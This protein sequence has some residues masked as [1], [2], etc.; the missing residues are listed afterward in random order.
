MIVLTF[1]LRIQ[2]LLDIKVLRA[3][4]TATDKTILTQGFVNPMI[5]NYQHRDKIVALAERKDAVNTN[6]SDKMP[7]PVR[8]FQTLLPFIKCRDYAETAWDGDN[9]TTFSQLGRNNTTEGM[10]ATSSKDWRAQN[11][12]HSRL[13]QMFSPEILF[14]P[15][16]I[17]S[18]YELYTVGLMKESFSANWSTETNP[19]SGVHSVEAKFLN[20]ISAGTPGVSIT[21]INSNPNFLMDESFFGPTNSDHDIA[22]H[23]VYREFKGTFHKATASDSV[24]RNGLYGT[25]ELTEKGADFT[26]Y[27]NDANVRYCNHYK[28]MLIDDWNRGG[29]VNN[30]AEI[31]I[32]GLSSEGAKCVTFMQGLMIISYSLANRKPIETIHSEAAT[33]ETNG[34]LLCE[35]V[36]DVNT[37][38]IV[39]FMEV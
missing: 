13:M 39:L 14:D 1:L 4:R 8:K 34:V 10:K 3:D 12:Q 32:L 11:F 35:F 19:T 23:Q 25:P 31:Q 22:T 16:S 6:K 26:T 9:D 29:A 37:K 24:R 38:Y 30:D 2:N 33:G 27:N 28:S 17:D 7:S 21:A 20:G 5:A 18:S 36:K 15:I